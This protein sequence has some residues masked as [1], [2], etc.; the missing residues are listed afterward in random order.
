MVESVGI[1]LAEVGFAVTVAVF[2]HADLFGI[3]GVIRE[4][5]FIGMFLIHS[6]SLSGGLQCVIIPGPVAVAAVV[7]HSTGKAVGFR[8]VYPALLVDGDCRGV[9]HVWL[10]REKRGGHAFRIFDRGE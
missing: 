1:D 3:L 4:R 8:D 7:L 10:A 9:L 2:D 6:Q 5:F